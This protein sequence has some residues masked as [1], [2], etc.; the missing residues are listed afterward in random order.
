MKKIDYNK[1]SKI[2]Y[3]LKNNCYTEQP[4]YESGWAG[5]SYIVDDDTEIEVS[6]CLAGWHK[7]EWRVDIMGDINK[8]LYSFREKDKHPIIIFDSDCK[9]LYELWKKVF[10]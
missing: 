5:D 7:G 1:F 2:V 8:N 3:G 9:S 4:N 10:D 6:V